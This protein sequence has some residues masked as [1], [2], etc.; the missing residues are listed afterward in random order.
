MVELHA[1]GAQGASIYADKGTAGASETIELVD[2]AEWFDANIAAD[3]EVYLKLNCEGAE[4]DVLERLVESGHAQRL[5]AALITFD[6]R[7][8]PS[9]AHREEEV[10]RRLAEAGVRYEV[11]ED[12]DPT[13]DMRAG[14]RRLLTPT[15]RSAGLAQRARYRLGFHLPRRR[16]LAFA[17]RAVLPGRCSSS[18]LAASRGDALALRRSEGDVIRL[19]YV[20]D[21]LGRSG[22]AE[23]ALAAMA[24]LWWQQALT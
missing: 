7:K 21:S 3:D 15:T 24:P 1:A 14:V 22:G 17:A 5:K 16:Q 2:V 12:V 19:A 6:I 23:Q 4:A 13:L 8:I 10:R 11:L 18:S 20:I 9:Q